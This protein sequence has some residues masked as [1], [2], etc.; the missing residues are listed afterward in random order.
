M[1]NVIIYTAEN[2]SYC[3]EAKEFLDANNI[4]Y[5]EYNVSKDVDARKE[6]MKRKVMSVPYILID[7]QGIIG[8]SVDKIKQLL[9]I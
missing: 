6:L 2:C 8:S 1:Q 7:G 4:S 5:T 3:H 9:N